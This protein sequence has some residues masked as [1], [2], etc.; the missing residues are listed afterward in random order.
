MLSLIPG[1]GHDDDLTHSTIHC[2]T[3]LLIAALHGRQPLDPMLACFALPIAGM[4]C[5]NGVTAIG[6]IR[7][8]LQVSL[9]S[10]E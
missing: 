10:T 8:I 1:A 4:G 3:R 6:L 9:M 2:N 5:G 7:D